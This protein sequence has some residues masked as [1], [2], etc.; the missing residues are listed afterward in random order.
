RIDKLKQIAKINFNYET[1]LDDN[2]F[3]IHMNK[4]QVKFNKPIY[5]G[6]TILELSKYIMFEFVYD[7]LKPK[8]GNNLTI[9]GGDTDSLFLEIRNMDFYEEIKPNIDEW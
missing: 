7:Y 2:L 4:M 1:I 6:F 3:A 5:V 8:F 9:C